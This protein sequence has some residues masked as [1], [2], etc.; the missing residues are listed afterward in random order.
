MP[1]LYPENVISQLWFPDGQGRIPQVHVLLDAARDENIYPAVVDFDG[2]YHCLYEIY[3][4][5]PK[6]LAEAAPYLIKLQPEHPFTTWLIS[7]GWGDSWGIFLESGASLTELRSHFRKF[8]MVKDEEGKELYFRYYDP[9]VL[10]PFLPTCNETELETFFGPV[11][12]FLVE[13]EDADILI[14]YSFDGSE[15]ASDSVSLET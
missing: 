1:Y 2:E 3:Q 13:G 6:A 4:G 10:R 15:L 9:R 7:E 11:D 14:E 12:R 8:L 5:I